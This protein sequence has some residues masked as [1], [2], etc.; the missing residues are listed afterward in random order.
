MQFVKALGVSVHNWKVMV[1][2]LFCQLLIIALVITCANLL[3]SDLSQQV[4]Q[5]ME[6]LQLGEFFRTVITDISEGS[7]N[8]SEFAVQLQDMIDRITQSIQSL[9]NFLNRV[10]LSY[11]IAIIIVCIYRMLV[12]ATDVTVA[13]QLNEFM[14]SNAR[15]PFTWYFFKKFGKSLRFTLLQFVISG[16]MDLLIIFGVAGFYVMF[17]VAFR[18]W[19]IIPALLLGLVLYTIRHVFL[20][21]WLPTIAATDAVSVYNALRDGIAKLM[22]CFWKVF[23]KNFVILLT[24][25]LLSVGVVILTRNLPETLNTSMVTLVATSIISLV[26]FFTMKCVNMA[27]YFKANNRPFF[28]K[29]FNVYGTEIVRKKAVK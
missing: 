1:K 16:P 6:S 14:T 11:I 17:L 21:F 3:F 20:A 19:A 25:V 27:E 2:A 4:S 29:R 13:Y 28:Y 10:E 8:S 12:S 15:R 7:F 18:W 23:W 24:V 26:G 9:P 5:I 22:Y